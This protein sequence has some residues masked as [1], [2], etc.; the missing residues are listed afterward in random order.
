[1]LPHAG[2]TVELNDPVTSPQEHAE[3]DPRTRHFSATG[4]GARVSCGRASKRSACYPY[5]GREAATRSQGRGV[6]PATLSRAQS[7]SERRLWLDDWEGLQTNPR[8]GAAHAE[9]YP[10]SGETLGE[11]RVTGVSLPVGAAVQAAFAA[12]V[13]VSVD[14]SVPGVLRDLSDVHRDGCG[15]PAFAG[16]A[17]GEVRGG[18]GLSRERQRSRSGECRSELGLERQQALV[19]RAP[20]AARTD[21]PGA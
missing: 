21:R 11:S 7:G 3:A 2:P 6:R 17:E 10:G 20:G 1:M 15:Q 13:S 5:P 18:R 12:P 14:R 16:G 9:G 4:P 8:P 19:G